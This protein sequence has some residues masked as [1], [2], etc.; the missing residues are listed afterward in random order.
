MNLLLTPEIESSLAKKA[1]HLGTTPQLLALEL[2]RKELLGG[3]HDDAP[4]G[5]TNLAKFLGQNVGVLSSKSLG[6][7][8]RLSELCGR[9]FAAGL[10]REHRKTSS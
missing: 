3:N 4:N 7:D 9:Q 6:S 5:A 8:G 1:Q 10:L 2:L